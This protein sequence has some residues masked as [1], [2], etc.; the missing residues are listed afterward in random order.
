MGKTPEVVLERNRKWR[1]R[2]R[3]KL[4]VSY[5]AYYD[6]NAEKIRADAKERYANNPE[7]SKEAC[8]AYY[9]NVKRERRRKVIDAL[10]GKCVIC[11]FADW[12]GLQVDHVHDGGTV[13]RKSF[14]NLWEYYKHIEQ[15]TDSGDYQVLCANCNQIKRYE[16]EED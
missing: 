12:R 14:T 4:R 10:G 2:N 6:A 15:N 9:V 16:K 7:K 3:E 1:E 8:R 11:G 13:H 5:K